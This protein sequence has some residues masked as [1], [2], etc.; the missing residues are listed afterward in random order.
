MAVNNANM[1]WAVPIV[2]GEFEAAYEF[3]RTHNV[4]QPI[5]PDAVISTGNL[6]GNTAAIEG[7]FEAAVW[8]KDRVSLYPANLLVNSPVY[9]LQMLQAGHLFLVL[10]RSLD[11]PAYRIIIT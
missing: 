7:D 6:T 11:F 9:R 4:L 5:H 8:V 1:F 10:L 3:Y 2:A